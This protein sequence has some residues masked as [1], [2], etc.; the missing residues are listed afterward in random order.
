VGG[1]Y[2][3]SWTGTALGRVG[4]NTATPSG[5]FVVSP[6][7]ITGQ[8]A[9]TTMSVEFNA[10]T[11]NTAQ[12][13]LGT[14]ATPFERRPI[15]LE[16]ALC[17]RY[18]EIG[19]FR[20]DAYGLSTNNFTGTTNY[21]ATKRVTPTIVFSGTGFI[22]A[23]GIYSDSISNASSLTIGAVTTSNGG[24]AFATTYTSAAEL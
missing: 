12:L 20:I 17:Q 15:G 22:N 10:G 13:E 21:K 18:F 2:V 5:T 19:I 1:S 16:L 4:I 3:L 14:V 6:I 8:T 9:G 7:L 24:C 23:S 11:L